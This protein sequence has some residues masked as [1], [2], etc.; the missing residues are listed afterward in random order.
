MHVRCTFCR[1]SFNLTRDFMVEAVSEAKE[2]RMKYVQVECLNCRK[3]IKVPVSQMKR[4]VP[5]SKK[6]ADED[7]S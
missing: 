7:A 2:K 6:P 4:Y 3:Q 1:H 5:E